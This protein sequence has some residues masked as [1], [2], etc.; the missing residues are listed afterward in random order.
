MH[1]VECRRN[2]QCYW[3]GRSW[4]RG[5]NCKLQ[6]FSDTVFVFVWQ[7]ILVWRSQ[8]KSYSAAFKWHALASLNLWKLPLWERWE[9]NIWWDELYL[10]D[11]I[12][13]LSYLYDIYLPSLS[14]CST[15]TFM[16][17]VSLWSSGSPALIMPKKKGSK[18]TRLFTFKISFLLLLFF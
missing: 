8:R 15:F 5:E 10:S 11:E 3:F 17:F 13:I 2:K 1:I 16:F 6:Y 4:T 18:H 7:C 9:I 12:F 14:L